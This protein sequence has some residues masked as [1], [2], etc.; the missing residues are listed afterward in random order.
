MILGVLLKV[1]KYLYRINK[2]KMKIIIKPIL[3]N[4]REELETLMVDYF[5]EINPSKIINNQL[6]Y[7]YLDDYWNEK[8]RIPLFIE[9]ENEI[10]GFVLI[11]DFT[12]YEPFNAIQSIAEFYIKPPFRRQNIGKETAFLLFNKYKGKWE[13]K[14]DVNSH[15]AQTFWRTIIEEFT[16]GDYQEIYY[17]EN[18]EKATI[19][20]LRSN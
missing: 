13:I 10:V 4:E 16:K 6:D 5:K 8:S 14:Q 11:N 12:L 20:L 15:G 1:S 17:D 2:P 18:N 19:Q 3:I 9:L 7:P